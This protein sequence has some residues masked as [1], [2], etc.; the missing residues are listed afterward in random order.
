[1]IRMAGHVRKKTLAESIC[2]PD[3]ECPI[4]STPPITP[5]RFRRA[6]PPR[7]DKIKQCCRPIPET[8]LYPWR[9]DICLRPYSAIGDADPLHVRF[10][11][12]QPIAGSPDHLA[13]YQPRLARSLPILVRLM[14]RKITTPQTTSPNT[15]KI[16][17]D[18]TGIE[19]NWV[20]S[21]ARPR[22][23]RRLR[24][25]YRRGRPCR[26]AKLP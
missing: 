1:M 18:R 22:K 17:T 2:E 15:S 25:S 12:S 8:P 24:L 13:D 21:L 10:Y 6:P 11:S 5:S 16:A 7:K 23:P 20:G 4:A 9:D 3:Q 19:D 26:T 14:T